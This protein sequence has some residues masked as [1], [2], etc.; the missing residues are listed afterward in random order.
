VALGTLV[1][2]QAPQRWLLALWFL[3]IGAGMPFARL[4]DFQSKLWCWVLA[5]AFSLTMDCVVAGVMIYLGLWSPLGGVIALGCLS[6]TGE[7]TGLVLHT[8]AAPVVQ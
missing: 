8:R 3:L 4:I 7:I 1:L 6:L 2:V 5:I